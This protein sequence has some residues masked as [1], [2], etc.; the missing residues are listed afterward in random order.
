MQPPPSQNPATAQPF[1]QPLTSAGNQVPK[2]K[3][4][5]AG[6]P[7]MGRVAVVAAPIV[8]ILMAIIVA[9]GSSGNSASNADA[10]FI[11][12]LNEGGVTYNSENNAIKVAHA[13][14]D[15]LDDGLSLDQVTENARRSSLGPPFETGY[16]VGAAV[17]AYCPK[18]GKQI[19]S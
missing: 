4:F 17:Y 10:R 18:Y 19:Y 7:T 11:A 3:G 15:A 2:T 16:V 1:P 12:R 8:V 5:W 13:V 6:L 14:C 9:V